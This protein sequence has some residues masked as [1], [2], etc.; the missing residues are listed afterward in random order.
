[1]N[2]IWGVGRFGWVD[3]GETVS[4]RFCSAVV[5]AQFWLVFPHIC[6]SF[7]KSWHI[8]TETLIFWQFCHAPE[9]WHRRFGSNYMRCGYKL[10]AHFLSFFSLFIHFSSFLCIFT[11]FCTGRVKICTARYQDLG[12]VF[13]TQKDLTTK[14]NTVQNTCEPLLCSIIIMRHTVLR[15]QHTVVFVNRFA[16]WIAVDFH[17]ANDVD[18]G[19][20][21]NITA[22]PSRTQ[23]M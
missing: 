12:I 4:R 16:V 6:C 7:G 1:M 13:W 21:A 20:R 5:K 9:N 14:H 15:R 3:N 2:W 23:N 11:H 17:V 19:I 8:L 18:A 22:P 10:P